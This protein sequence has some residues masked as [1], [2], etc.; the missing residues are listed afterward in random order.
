NNPQVGKGVVKTS[1]G[2]SAPEASTSA[3]IKQLAAGVEKMTPRDK[4]VLKAARM[5]PTQAEMMKAKYGPDSVKEN[6]EK[7]GLTPAQKKLIVYGAL[8][9]G[10]AGLIAYGVHSE[11]ASALA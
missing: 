7:K 3:A 10:V 8:G 2:K 11:N 6:S 5:S 9:L 1:I 4:A